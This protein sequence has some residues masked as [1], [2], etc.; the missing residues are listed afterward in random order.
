MP[1]IETKIHPK[2]VAP[3]TPNVS[4][5]QRCSSSLHVPHRCSVPTCSD[6]LL[7]PTFMR[8][9][10]RSGFECNDLHPMHAPTAALG[11]VVPIHRRD[12]RR[13]SIGEVPSVATRIAATC[14]GSMIRYNFRGTC[15][16]KDDVCSSAVL[17]RVAG[18]IPHLVY[19]CFGM[20]DGIVVW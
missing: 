7:H 17:K 1:F 6:P 9:V 12:E 2:N 14:A 4:M 11:G 3:T 13:R 19:L 15:R 16:L 8:Q 10:Q 20:P 18:R 5:G